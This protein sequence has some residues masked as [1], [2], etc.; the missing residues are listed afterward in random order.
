MIDPNIALSVRNPQFKSATEAYG[1]ALT[2]KNMMNQGKQQD[3]QMQLAQKELETYDQRAAQEGQKAQQELDLNALKITGQQIENGIKIAQRVG[4]VLNQVK[5]PYQY[6]MARS[7]LIAELGDSVAQ[8]LPEQY[9]PAVVEI[10]VNETLSVSEQLAQIM[11]QQKYRDAQ[12]QQGIENRQKEDEIGLKRRELDMKPQPTTKVDVI[13]LQM[14]DG[15]VKGFNSNDVQGINQ[16]VQNGAVERGMVQPVRNVSPKELQ[17]AKGKIQAAQILKQQIAAAR[18]KFALIKE[19]AAAG[20]S[21]YLLPLSEKGQNFDAAI[22]ALRSSVTALTRTPGVGAMSDFETKL[23]QSK[24]P[25][26]NEYESTTEQ[27]LKQLEDLANQIEL[28]YSSIL[29]EG[30]GTVQGDTNGDGVIDWND[31]P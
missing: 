20:P 24:I 13:N 22:D 31:L 12:T 26:R 29:D 6:Q 11:E 3:M 1:Q 9:D 2:L 19:T 16:A 21:G 17:A 5:D 7:Q 8:E 30:G 27:K 28:G 10:A 25:S 15:T 14:P 18:E 4:S 23:D